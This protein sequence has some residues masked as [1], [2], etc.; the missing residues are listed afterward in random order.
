M[1]EKQ[2]AGSVLIMKLKPRGCRS[3]ME[4][5]MEVTERLATNIR[6]SSGNQYITLLCS[7][8]S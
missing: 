5:A 8:M 6:C 4:A 2:T 7:E 1:K 3:P